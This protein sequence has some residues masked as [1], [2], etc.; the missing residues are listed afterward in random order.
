MSETTVRAIVLRRRDQ[1]EN[2]RSVTLLTAESGKVE[3]IAKGARKAGSRL[4]AVTEP[5]TVATLG[6]AAGRHRRFITQA[7]PESSFRGLRAD[8]DR[9]AG[10]LALAELFAEIIPHEEPA[11]EAFA[12][13]WRALDGLDRHDRPLAVLVWAELR[14][15]L[16]SGYLPDFMRCVA[17]GEPIS[18]AEPWLSPHA[19]GAISAERATAYTDRF[20][21]RRE[22]TLGLAK[23]AEL[24]LPPPNLK[25]AEDCLAA[26]L[27]FWK[28]IADAPLLANVHL[29]RT[30]RHGAV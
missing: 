3:A 20:R 25:F 15:M 28:A 5:L 12:L 11:P 17:T 30:V 8:Y 24:E 7:Q 21:V 10:G 16:L 18:E 14:L 29:V 9:L 2:D 27:P 4:A 22:V 19:G 13:L 6:L 26:L 1:G 23:C